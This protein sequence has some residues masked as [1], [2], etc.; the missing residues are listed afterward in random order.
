MVLDT[1]LLN[2]QQYKVRIGVVTIEKGGLLVA[3]DY[4]RQLYL[5]TRKST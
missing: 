5:L 3:L 2:S 4:G 1:Y